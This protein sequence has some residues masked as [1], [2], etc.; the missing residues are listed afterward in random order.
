[1]TENLAHQQYMLEE[2]CMERN[3]CFS[4]DYVKKL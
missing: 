4:S 2:A 3:I 1:M